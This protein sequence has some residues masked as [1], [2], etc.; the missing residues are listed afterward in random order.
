MRIAIIGASSNRAK[1]G[2]KAVRSYVSQGNEVFPIN[3]T[4]TEIEGLKAYS[5]ILD[6]P[7]SID[8]VALYVPPKV[9]V[10]LLEDIA[11]K[12]VKEVFVNPGAESDELFAKGTELNLVLV[13]A[14][15]IVE[16]GDSPSQY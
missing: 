16:I 15:A 12:G 14:C 1:Y 2:N 4:E 3:P 5:S 6:V 11:A 13:Y 7:G 10:T 8:R 9:G